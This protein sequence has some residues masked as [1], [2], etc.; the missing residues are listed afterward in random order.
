M[1][2]LRLTASLVLS[3]ALLGWSAFA[4]QTQSTQNPPPA[5]PKEGQK[6]EEPVK[7]TEPKPNEKAQQ[8]EEA[9][10]KAAEDKEK[11]DQPPAPAPA[12][13]TKPAEAKPDAK[14]EPKKDEKKKW[15]VNNPPGPRTDVQID[16]DEGTWMNVD[17]SPDGK[18]IAFELLGDLYVIPATGGDAKALT[19][20]FAWDMQPRF[21]PDGKWIAFTSD[22]G[23]GDNIWVMKRDGTDPQQVTKETFRLLN[24]PA[25]SPDG[26]FIVARKHFTSTRSLGAGEM[27]LYHRSGGDGLQ[28]TK[29]PNDQ[30]DAGEPVFSHDGRYI[31]F[32]Q[33][34]TPGRVFEYNKDPN[35]QIYV[36]QRFDRQTGDTIAFVT[37]PGGAI[38][39]TPSRDGK[40][41]A[42][43]RRVRYKST[44]FI[45]D[46][47]SGLERP[48]YDGLERDMQETWAIHGVYPTMAWTPDNSAIVFWSRGKIHRIDV[49]S[50]QVS[51]IPFR[52]KGTRAITEVVRQAQK[53]APEN[54]PTRMLRWVN[55]SPKGDRVVYGALGHIYVRALPEGTPKRLT[56]QNDDFEYYPSISRDGNWVVFASWND[57]KYGRVRLANLNTGQTRDVTTEA[58]H[59]SEPVLSPDGKTIVYRKLDDSVIRGEGH[60]L[61]PGLYAVAAEGAD[62][63]K[64]ISKSG[65][66]AHFGKDNDRVFFMT[67]EA[68][69]K[70]A[71]RSVELTGAEERTLL[72]AED[73]TEMRVSPDQRWLAF[74]ERFN[75]YVTPFAWAGLSVSIGPDSKTMPLTKVSRDAGEYL[76]WSGDSNKL[77]WSLGSQLYSR[78]LKDTFKFMDGAP[79]ELPEPAK[80]G[81]EIGFTQKYSAPETT[82]AF[83]NAR[84]ITMKGNEVIENG[85]IVV[86]GNRITALGKNVAVPADA[87][88]FDVK[89]HTIVPG[90]IDAHWHGA[91]GDD[92]FIP[93][94]NYYNYNSL[95]F[96]VT[97]IHD[98]STDTSTFFSASEMQKAGLIVGPRLTS[99]G[100]ILYGAKAPFKAVIE[101]YD[102]AL[103]HL[104]RMQAVGGFSVK[105]YNQPRRDQRQ[106]VIAAAREL[107]MEVVPEGGSLFQHNMTQVV[108]GHTTIEHS[109]PVPNIYKDVIQLWGK[110]KTGYTPTL[111]VSYGGIMGENYWYAK[112]NVWDN[113]RLMSFTPRATVDP[114]A[115]RPKIVAPD[116]EWNHI[117][118]SRGAK[119]LN[120]A[121]VKVS[122]GAH[123]Q[124]EGLGFHWEVWMMQQGGMTPM[125]ALRTATINPAQVLGFDSEIGSLEV[126]KLADFVVLTKNPLDDIKNTESI[127]YTVA[128]GR[129][130]DAM[131]MNEATRN[132]KQRAKFF[133]ERNGMSTTT[134]GYSIHVD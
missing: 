106:M 123:G 80:Q 23:N 35:T 95:A 104:R 82:I 22:R 103:A 12:E 81:T 108:D 67:I 77:Y 55:V 37:G 61:N 68:E 64:L 63:P 74:T 107:G 84:L 124:R 114:V 33:D 3:L 134:N 40:S 122:S 105:S 93:Q 6:K 102:D 92:E 5:P 34:T 129:L 66:N 132:G 46:L 73:A 127:K 83:T 39:P 96:G 19:S 30:K 71:L 130:Y 133:W 18:E 36:I 31:Y 119:M 90:F 109:L 25:W 54:F 32:S 125:E 2:A 4:Q 13:G 69:N 48:I 112:T 131:T 94:Q 111:V 115:R 53:L 52:V 116:D 14:A 17:V 8:D 65:F 99:T 110:A 15:D 59:Y 120:D 79:K 88:R 47:A 45:K 43:I 57:E 87:Q 51:T 76:H 126:G 117:N 100:T 10:K 86:K 118:V 113:R 29:R 26:E 56:Q 41:L 89:G 91:Q 75:A 44:L 97:T 11:K 28:L 9:K 38:R 58:G 121:G 27:W 1:K 78:D 60:G 7:D 21:S 70:R 128:N 98:P 72:L 20:G 24:A 50:K 42:F 62:K 101:S 85:T 49:N 16:T